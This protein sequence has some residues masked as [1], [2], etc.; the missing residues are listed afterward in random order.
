[1]ELGNNVMRL[2]HAVCILSFHSTQGLSIFTP[3]IFTRNLQRTLFSVQSPSKQ[4]SKQEQFRV[5]T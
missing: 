4:A 1:M 5:G 2:Y 3:S